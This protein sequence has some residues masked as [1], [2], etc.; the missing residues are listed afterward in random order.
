[1]IWARFRWSLLAVVIVLTSQYG[2]AKQNQGSALAPAYHKWLD[3]DVRWLISAEE[4]KEFMKLTTDEQR[5]HFVVEFWE[6]RNPNPGS[7]DNTFKKEHYR[8]LAFSNQHFA[9]SVPGWKTDRGRVYVVYG[10]PD[11]VIQHP[12]SGTNP[13]EELWS[14]HMPGADGDVTLRFVDRCACGELVLVTDPPRGR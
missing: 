8:R 12:P 7:N 5:D 2:T 14:Y 11:S 3:D 13:P 4:E 10:P 6:K 9:A 1:M